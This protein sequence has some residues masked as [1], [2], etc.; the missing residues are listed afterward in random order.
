MDVQLDSRSIRVR[1]HATDT[2]ERG[3]PWFQESKSQPGFKDTP[4]RPSRHAE[5][6]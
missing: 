1:L 2:P 6:E 5:I 3:Q 4:L